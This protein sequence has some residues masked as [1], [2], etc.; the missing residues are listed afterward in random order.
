MAE[1]DLTEHELASELIFDGA[2]LKVK[3]DTVSL[4]DGTT[5]AREYIDHPGAVC[6]IPVLDSG[7][8]VME[9]QYRYPLRAEMIELPA[10]KMHRGEDLLECARRE[11]QEETGY[12]ASKWR[13]LT[14]YH[15]LIA[16]STERIEILLATGLRHEGARLDEGEFLEIFP[17]SLDQGMEWV[18]TG[19]I[20]DS[21]TII[22]LFWLEKLRSGAWPEGEIAE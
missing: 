11:L 10:G 15:P 12:V 2:L 19:R 21:K 17:M 5:G 4:P 18:R 9:R 16:Y 3:R 14:A 8:I 20:T 1:Q 22:G 13:R 7:E 6:I